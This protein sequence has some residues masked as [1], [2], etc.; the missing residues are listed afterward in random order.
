MKNYFV[1]ALMAMFFLASPLKAQDNEPEKVNTP[2]GW[3]LG[4]QAG[5]P[6]AEAN[7]SSFGADRLRPG[8]NAGLHTGYAFSRIISLEFF[9]NWGQQVLTVQDCC[10]VRD[11][12][13][14]EDFK[15]YRVAPEGM[16][17]HYYKDLKSNAFLQRYAMQANVNILGFFEQTKESP[18]KLELSPSISL[19]CSNTDIKTK[20]DNEIVKED[21]CKCNFG[22]GGNLGLSYD[23]ND[24]INLGIYGGFTHLAGNPIDAMPKLHTTN[25]IMDLGLKLSINLSKKKPAKKPA[26][27]N[28]TPSSTTVASQSN[29][30]QPDIVTV[31]KEEKEEKPAKQESVEEE[32]FPVIY[33]PFNKSNIE[34]R[35]IVKVMQTAEILKNNKSMRVLVTGWADEVGTYNANKRISTQ[36]AIAVKQMLMK[37]QI[38][39]DRIEVRGAAVNHEAL[40]HDEARKVTITEIK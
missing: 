17:G 4:V 8:W 1:L 40:T 22:I 15:R 26:G 31:P 30:M 13:L 34:E 35:E 9:A 36:R 29:A 10:F 16:N 37:M 5:M 19:V 6:Y 2:R 14:G 38:S 28:N 33:F 3:Y 25:F 18:W 23:I 39:G 11:Y 21:V 20:N 32:E 27:G 24:D 12:F 7:F